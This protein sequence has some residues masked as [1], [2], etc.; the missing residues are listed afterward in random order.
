MSSTPEQETEPIYDPVSTGPNPAGSGFV[1]TPFPGNQ[2]P[3]N[4]LDP[5]SLK[6][7]NY[8]HSSTLPGLTNNYTQFSSSPQNRDGLVARMDYNES[9]KS[10]WMGRYNWGDENQSNEGLGGAGSKILTNYEQYT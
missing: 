3:Q 4:R 10:Q 1:R 2:I 9:P 7:L 5:I 8:Y 6:L